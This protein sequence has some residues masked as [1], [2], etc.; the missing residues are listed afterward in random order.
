MNRRAQPPPDEEKAGLAVSGGAHA[1]LIVAAIFSGQLFRADE[2]QAVRISDVELITAA[3]FEAALS[4]APAGPRA[5]LARPAAPAEGAD[6][7]EAPAAAET[8]PD[9]AENA[10][11]L[12]PARADAAP[13]VSSADA[14]AAAPPVARPDAPASADAVPE[15]VATLAAPLPEG[16]RN[17]DAPQR[18]GPVPLDAAPPRPADRVA[19]TPA[20]RPETIAEADRPIEAAAPADA[21]DP[22]RAVE[23]RAPAAP[24]EAAPQIVTEADEVSDESRLA[25]VASAPPVGR[26]D[27]PPARAEAPEAPETP[28]QVAA[29]ETEEP[30]PQADAEPAREEERPRRP[31]RE[32]SAPLGAALTAGEVRGVKLGIQKYWRMDRVTTLPNYEELVV[33]MRIRLD[34]SGK[35]IGKP[36]PVRPRTPPDRRFGVAMDAARIA[37]TRAGRKGFDL[38]PEKYG[39]WQVIEVTFNPGLG[40]S[41]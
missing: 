21:A 10:P 20:P 24:R 12:D 1:L 40:V 31:R 14:A 41:M 5:D 30:A 4:S 36:E 26:P 15:G 39:R 17:L 18:P 22:E 27:P 7:P 25:P 6:A 8:G 19:P 23:A 35:M 28:T 37:L 32:T 29:A 3:E 13:A 33:V 2:A 34:K 11:A 16:P 38:P 9:R